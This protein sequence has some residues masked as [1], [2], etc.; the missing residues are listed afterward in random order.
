MLLG[1]RSSI[2]RFTTSSLT[3]SAQFIAKMALAAS[4]VLLTVGGPFSGSLQAADKAQG[5]GDAP[6][7][8]GVK[9]DPPA[10]VVQWPETLDVSIPQPARFEELL[11]PTRTSEFCLAGLAAY[12]S[13]RAELWNLVTGKRVGAISGT[14]PKANKRALS[15]DGKFLAVAVLDRAQ[16][17]DVEV[18]SLETGRRVSN[19]MADYR[20]FSM[21][22]LDFAGPGEVVT[23][24]LGQQNG[25]FGHHLRVWDANTGAPL[26]QMD[27]D[28]NISG[29]TRY[30]I[31][32]GGK[33]LASIVIPEVVIYDL[34]TGQAKANITPPSKTEGGEHVS[35]DNVRFSPDGSEIALLAEGQKSAVLKVLD[36]NTGETKVTH[37]LAASMK[38]AL[39]N[40][41]SYKGPHIEFVSQPE[42]FLWHGSGFIE[43][44]SGLMVW[45]YR[46]GQLEFSHWKRLLT[47][48]GLIV[49]TGG[50]DSRKIEVLPF[51][52]AKLQKTLEAY[53]SDGPAIIKPGEKVKVTVKVGE[54]RFGKPDEAK[55]SIETVLAERLADD[56]LEV[57]E[58]GGTVLAVQY[59]EMAG[60]TLQEVK[61]GNPIRGGGTPT[62]RTIQS[63]AGELQIKWTTKDG[64]TK[65]YEHVLNLDPSYLSVRSEGEI[66]DATA[67]KQ[68][69]EILKIQLAG[70]PMPYFMSTDKELAVLPMATTSEMASP[71]SPKDALKKKIDAKKKMVKKGAK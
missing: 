8:W 71:A 67:R 37:E 29:D 32:P 51:P 56:G 38:S 60:K 48:A 9:A 6:A 42:G 43:R 50:H 18:W 52:S 41:A 49:S 53:R 21:T 66:T 65:V 24:T 5:K 59:K 7:R 33:W 28:K 40:P 15:P 70:L 45:T 16:A 68:V 62:G 30:D 46:Q 54:V 4:V 55:Q 35:I 26:R 69:F 2:R 31:S 12:E 39:Q 36:L 17:N 64:K 34:Q 58:D 14:P 22:I 1:T 57:S 23:Y 11:F 63:T 10:S 19:F 25:K 44:D 47:P 20:E 13:E 61:G 3:F 27:L